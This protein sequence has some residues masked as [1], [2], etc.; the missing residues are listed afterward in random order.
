MPEVSVIIPV[1]NVEKYLPQCL[2]SVSHQTLKEIEII[3]VD[4]GSTDNSSIILDTY[5]KRDSR[6]NII[7][8]DNEGYGKSMNTGL[9]MANG[10][11]IAIVESD[12][13]VELDMLEKLYSA[14]IEI[15]ADITKA[16]HYNYRKGM[17]KFCDWLK[18]FPKK[19]VINSIEFPT[20]L[21]KANTIWTCLFKRSF[22][23][24]HGIIFHET[25]GASYQD[26]SFAIQGWLWAERVYL[27]DD[28]VLHYRNDNPDS[29]MYNPDKVFC[30]FDEYEWLEEKFHKFW[31]SK[32]MLEDYF[33]ATKYMDYL[34]HYYRVAAQYQYALLLRIVESLE[35]DS[36]NGRIQ[37][38]AFNPVVL[39]RL[40]DISINV[41]K[42]F[43]R[44]AKEVRDLRLD[45]CKFGNID[46]YV[47][48]FVHKMAMF[49]QVVIYGAGKI[50]QRIAYVLLT[51]GVKI[52]CF[53]VT[54]KT[55]EKS[56]CM[57]ISIRELKEINGLTNSCAVIIAVT[58]KNQY[59][60]YQ[61]LVKY[62][63]KNI[64][65]VD[66][67]VRRIITNCVE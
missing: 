21:N 16:N 57:G 54:D 13:F 56:E 49:Q 41:N 59:E 62:E 22:L 23:N 20:L 7:H 34:N 6:I 18:D 2:E 9:A 50:G 31:N 12:D 60:L 39:E 19:Q 29:S 4:D 44:T 63:F 15:D 32:P 55:S 26:I 17:D 51:R 47:N 38:V 11:Y 1:Y 8:K 30:V 65:R 35:M 53:V 46:I 52:D 10:T 40:N 48:A 27:L 58:E 14:A 5:A 61:N 66:D 24:K 28:A 43:Q 37:A 67:V 42:F 33:V 64:F 3:C 25:P 36:R 45:I